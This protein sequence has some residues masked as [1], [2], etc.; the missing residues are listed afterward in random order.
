MAEPTI[1]RAY[2]QTAQHVHE[3][4]RTCPSCLWNAGHASD[5]HIGQQQLEPPPFDRH[6]SPA[7]LEQR[8]LDLERELANTRRDLEWSRT[9]LAVFER[10]TANITE[11]IEAVR[12]K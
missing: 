10:L 6:V 2:D 12:R 3:Q 4:G 11:W 9:R 5:C 8:I 1:D 7:V